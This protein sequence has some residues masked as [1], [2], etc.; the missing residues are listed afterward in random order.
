MRSARAV[1]TIALALL[2]A[3]SAR[4]LRAAEPRAMTAVDLIGVPRLA[5]PQLSPDGAQ[6][7]FTRTEASWKANRAVSHIHRENVD[8]RGAR[9]M[10]SGAEGESSPRWSPDGRWIAFLAARP[11]AEGTQVQVM[12]SDGGEARALPAHPTDVRSLRWAGD[13]SALYFLA[14]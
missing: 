1:S 13:G 11:G 8:G 12:A 3:G 10:T 14:A 6:V 9:Q 5:D 4:S 7:L 2:A